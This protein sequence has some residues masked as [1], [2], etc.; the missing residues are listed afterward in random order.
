MA[1]EYVHVFPISELDGFPIFFLFGETVRVIHR[2]D[3]HLVQD[4]AQGDQVFNSEPP[5][6]NLVDYKRYRFF[7]LHRTGNPDLFHFDYIA[8]II[9][10]AEYI[11]FGY[12]FFRKIDYL[13]FLEGLAQDIPYFLPEYDVEKGVDIFFRRHDGGYVRIRPG[14]VVVQVKGVITRQLNIGHE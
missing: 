9:I 2:I 7:Y 6:L 8:D 12:Q 5:A 11:L 1:E 3:R 10:E 14:D 13:V 4:E